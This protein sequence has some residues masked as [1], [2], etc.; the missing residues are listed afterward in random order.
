[1]LLSS[2]KTAGPLSVCHVIDAMLTINNYDQRRASPYDRRRTNV[3][4]YLDG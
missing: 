4:T 1:M 2:E 3:G